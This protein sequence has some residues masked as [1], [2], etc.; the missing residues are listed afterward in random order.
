HPPAPLDE[1]AP[2]IEKYYRMRLT[3][4]EMLEHLRDRHIDKTRHGLSLTSLKR[5]RKG[6][7][8]ES[9]RQ[10]AHTLDTAAAAL[11]RVRSRYPKAGAR[12]MITHAFREEHIKVSRRVVNEFFQEY[13][14]EGMRERKAKW[15][16]RRRFWAAGV[17]DIW[18]ID[19]HDKWKQFNLWLHTGIEP[20]SGLILWMKVWWTNK[21]PCLIFHYCLEQAS[22]IG[23]IPMVMQSDPGSE[24]YGVANAHMALRHILDPSLEGTRQHLWMRKHNNIK[25]EIS[26]SQLRRRFTPGFEDLL[27]QGVQSGLY[28]PDNRLDALVF[29]WLFIPWLQAELDAWKETHNTA[30]KRADKNKILPHGRP[31]V[32]FEAPHMYDSMA[33]KISHANLTQDAIEDI[34]AYY[35]PSQDPVFHLIPPDFEPLVQQVYIRMG[36]LRIEHDSI[37]E[38]YANMVTGV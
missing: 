35:A 17:N 36:S 6:L 9:T 37:W 15:L 10:Q 2:H 13:E 21:N 7:G 14:P 38:I 4:T 30:P 34:W 8:L 18:A 29:H 25:P 23:R 33:F 26:W 31:Q 3:D 22:R 16:K 12:D 11:L 20:Y 32:I 19:Q 27:E 1:L 5:M 28:D 24:N